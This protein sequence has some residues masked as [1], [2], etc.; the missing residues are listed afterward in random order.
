MCLIRLRFWH[1]RSDCDGGVRLH[2]ATYLGCGKLD[3]FIFYTLAAGGFDIYAVGHGGDE[4][5]IPLTAIAVGLTFGFGLLSSVIDCGFYLGF[6]E[7]Y[8]K[9]LP[10]Y[11]ARGAIFYAVHISTNLVVFPTLFP[12]LS[13]KLD[14]IKQILH[15]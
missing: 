7:N 13:K 8:F 5:R 3:N 9:N 4:K 10:I 2:R 1:L 6:N 12:F 15:L 14:R 11:Y